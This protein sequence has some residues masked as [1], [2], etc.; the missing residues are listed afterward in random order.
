[1][2]EDT[3]NEKNVPTA[4]I[5][6]TGAIMGEVGNEHGLVKLSRC[7]KLPIRTSYWISRIL[8]KIEREA[9]IYDEHYRKLVRQ[10]CDKDDKGE[11]VK[12]AE[13]KVQITENRVEFMEKLNELREAQVGTGINKISLRLDTIPEGVINAENI[14][15]L[16]PF[17]DLII[18][19][20][21]AQE[22]TDGQP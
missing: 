16:E 10:C 1:M 22:A 18:D 20:A 13:D 4:E 3:S 19:E 17:F 14:I 11:P 7:D 8:A 6:L 2:A 21:P 9:K 15:Q 5:I 12:L